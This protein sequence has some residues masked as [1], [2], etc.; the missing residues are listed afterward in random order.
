MMNCTRKLVLE[1]GKLLFQCISLK[2]SSA[3][4]FVLDF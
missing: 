1:V 2:Y 4:S 3:Q